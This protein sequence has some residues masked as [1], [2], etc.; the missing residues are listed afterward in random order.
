MILSTS[1]NL[2]LTVNPD[3]SQVEE[4]R[5]QTNLDR[6]E[7]FYPERRQFFLENSDLF[8]S[9]GNSQARPFFSRRIGLNVPVNFG[10][11]L[12]GRIGKRW[13]IG[14]MDMQTGSKGEIRSGNYAVAVLQREI[15]SRSSITGFIVNKNITESF[16]DSSFTGYRYNRVAGLEYNFATADNRWQGKLFYHQSFYP[17]A[18][19]DAGSVSGNISYSSQYL[20]AGIS[21][22]WIGSDYI[23]E[24]GYIRRTGF[25]EITPSVSYLFYPARSERIISHGPGASLIAIF[26]PEF[27]H[28]DRETQLSYNIE[29][30][31]KSQLSFSM[32]EQFVKLSR[33][34]DPTN[35]GGLKLEAGEQFNWK[36]IRAGFTSDTRRLFNYSVNASTGGY[37]NGNRWNVIGI[38]NYRV[39][40]Y[41]SFGM[42]V[43]YNNI[44]LPEPYNSARLILAGPKLDI[45]FTDKI[46]LTTFV[47]YN[48]QIDN[49][50]M[51]IRFQWRFAPVSDLFIVYTG[52][53]FTDNFVNRNRGLVVKLSYWFN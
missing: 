8:A 20:K 30:R 33:D 17:G 52:N 34:F 48:N 49:L 53:S 18:G 45:T 35:T 22:S 10:G 32:E 5:Q 39:Q 50:N 11:R 31:N 37:Y 36:S 23:A 51:N 4:D 6:F 38:V 42:T 15:F 3:Y 12:T 28:S 21:Q 29:W 7:L 44:S 40:P 26:D 25:Y 14:M 16:N 47:Q 2:D 13:R 24:A 1:L 43:S 9:L 46:F 19:M 27:N 41:G